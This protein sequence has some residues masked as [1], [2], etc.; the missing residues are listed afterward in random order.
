MYKDLL[1]SQCVCACINSYVQL[2]YNMNLY[3]SPFLYNYEFTCTVAIS[4]VLISDKLLWNIVEK[5]VQKYISQL[6]LPILIIHCYCVC[7]CTCVVSMC[8]CALV[9]MY[10]HVYGSC[11]CICV[12]ILDGLKLR[13]VVLLD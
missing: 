6:L 7:L 2:Q 1:I 9:F 8:V 10:A 12:P 5:L 11:T 4:F 3:A 13:L